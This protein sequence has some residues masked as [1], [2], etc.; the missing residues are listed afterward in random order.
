MLNL[1]AITGHHHYAKCG[2]LYLQL[3]CSLGNKHPSLYKKFSANGYHAVRRSNRFW[4]GLSTDLTIEQVM[5]CD[6]KYRCGLMHGCGMSDSMQLMWICSMHKSTSI[7]LALISLAHVNH[8]P[9]T[10]Q[11]ADMGPSR[12]KRD[13]DDLSK[14]VEFQCWVVTNYK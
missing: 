10:T 4:A 8:M 11:H 12:E 1:L 3:M 7:H 2:R 5:M 6:I 13:W 14:I 9:D